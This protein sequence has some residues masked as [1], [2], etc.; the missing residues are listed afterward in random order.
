MAG[1]VELADTGKVCGV[2]GAQ[3]V[4]RVVGVEAGQRV[5][6]GRQRLL[7]VAAGFT[8]GVVSGLAI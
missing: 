3:V 5:R 6:L 8:E 7:L 1:G 4:D 2:L